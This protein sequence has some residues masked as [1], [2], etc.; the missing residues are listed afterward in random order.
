MNFLQQF[1]C[2]VCD[3]V[4]DTRIGMSNRD[5]QPFQFACPNCENNISFTLGEGEPVFNG[6]ETVESNDFGTTN[7]FI[8]LHLDFPVGF[9]KYEIGK[10]AFLKITSA[11]GHE[12]YLM[13]NAHLNGMNYIYKHRDKLQRLITQYKQGNYNTFSNLMKELPTLKKPR[14]LKI[15]DILSA[16][17][18]ATS[19]MSFPFTIHAHN[20]EI[21][22]KMPQLLHYIQKN[23]PKQLNKFL[24]DI[25][26]S[27][28]LKSLHFDCLSLYPKMLDFELPSRP[29]LYYD[30]DK[31]VDLSM[32][33]ARVST[34]EFDDCNN[35]YKDLSEV[36]SRQLI[37]VA[38]LNNLLKRGDHNIFDDSV[39]LNKKGDLIKGFSSLNEYANVDLGTKISGLDDS[40]YIV[41]LNALDNKLRNG[42][43][44]YK[45]EYK[46][47]I[48][49][50][51][52]YFAKEGMERTKY[53][54]LSFM[55]FMRKLLLLFREVHSINHI[56]KTLYFYCI[57]IAKKKI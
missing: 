2:L 20:A 44:H 13:L 46:E 22:E 34:A 14:S 28:F 15:Q 12:K 9:G 56:I 33:P 39:R 55:S 30:Y 49:M 42:I 6:A 10:T 5:I 25:I 19:A 36:F 53:N 48:Q 45:Y 11:I 43:A 16:L 1:K 57:F 23:H 51:T 35:F 7:P 47:S 4:I 52:Y 40:F 3:T 38:G 54:E 32:I 21:S 17:Y 27:G 24:D 50:I 41:D 8:D 29:A 26:G 31:N 37:I 18:T